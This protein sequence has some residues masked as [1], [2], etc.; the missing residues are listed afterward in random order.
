[1]QCPECVSLNAENP[2]DQWH[3]KLCVKLNVG[4]Q[5]ECGGTNFEWDNHHELCVNKNIEEDL[6]VAAGASY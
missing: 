2:D 3:G 6:C 5:G 1:M 4:E